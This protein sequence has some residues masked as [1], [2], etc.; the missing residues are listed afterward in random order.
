MKKVKPPPSASFLLGRVP[1]NYTEDDVREFFKDFQPIETIKF[2]YVSKHLF[3][4]KVTVTFPSM[5]I[6]NRASKLIG[7]HVGKDDLLVT[8]SLRPN[9]LSKSLP[10]GEIKTNEMKDDADI[11]GTTYAPGMCMCEWACHD[12]I[13]PNIVPPT[14]TYLGLRFNS[15][16]SFELSLNCLT[17]LNLKGND[18]K[19]FPAGLSFPV[20]QNLTISHNLLEELPDFSIFAPNIESIDATTNKLTEIHPSIS[21]LT[22]LN[23]FDVSHNQISKV[24]KL[25][26]SLRSILLHSN[27]ITACEPMN[28]IKIRELSLWK[29]K[30]EEVPKF[31]YGAIDDVIICHNKLT[32]IPLECIIE[33]VKKLNLCM[34]NIK[35]I[36]PDLFKIKSLRSLILFGNDISEIPEEF[37]KSYLETLDISENPKISKLPPVPYQLLELKFNFCNFSDLDHCVSSMNSL[38][39]IHCIGN[40]LKSLPPLPNIEEILAPGNELTEFPKIQ[41]NFMQQ[42]VIDLSHNKISVLPPMNAPFR[43]LDLSYNQITELPEQFFTTRSH[44]Y[45]T[46]NPIT[47][48]FNP[49][50]MRRLCALDVSHTNVTIE[51]C[52]EY[53][54]NL[55]EI[56]TSY[57]GQVPLDIVRVFFNTDDTVSHAG[58]IGTRATMEDCVVMRQNLKPG[59]SMFGLF[60]GHGGDRVSRLAAIGFPEIIAD[61]DVIDGDALTKICNDYYDT[62]VSTNETAG[63]TMDLAI[64][65]DKNILISHIGDGKLA[66]FGEDGSLQF[67]THAQNA[68]M[69]EE[70][71]RLRKQKIKLRRMR[72]AG[73]LAMSRAIGDVQVQ[74]VSHEPQNFSFELK[75]E[76]HRWLVIACDGI[77]DDLDLPSMGKTL[78]NTN[79]AIL[80]AT[81]LRDQAFSR[82]SEDN[83]SAI[84][85]DLKPLLEA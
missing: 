50:A 13:P 61:L 42:M 28:A 38:T 22:K 21:N 26:E 68:F 70:L 82:G 71:E 55:Y 75:K 57:N 64:I 69:R 81:Y 12:E 77:V 30:I 8:Y 46:G 31:A 60:D 19:T 20:L 74:G 52:D 78:V 15:L 43:L 41:C 29:N 54:D 76:L 24:P 14:T 39:K 40:H 53:P 1:L 84:V 2:H 63:T 4:R 9:N 48:T 7:K 35:E 72:T 3:T 5:E 62:I 23:H 59:V 49:K 37:S 67:Q 47:A 65:Q 6:A 80:G 83:I 32:V 56:A 18:I 11:P 36:P 10:V 25:P 58:M 73:T 85:I 27:Q 16:K 33:N 44:I 17:T 79:S 34:N 66:I 51:D 45:L